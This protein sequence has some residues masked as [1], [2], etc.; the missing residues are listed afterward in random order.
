MNSYFENR[1]A[2][3]KAQ[4]QSEV[5]D[6]RNYKISQADIPL[7]KENVEQFFTDHPQYRSFPQMVSLLS[8]NDG[9]QSDAIINLYEFA[10]HKDRTAFIF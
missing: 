7:S 5:V 2:F 10:I 4:S 9:Q 1:T 6:A 8:N 3:K